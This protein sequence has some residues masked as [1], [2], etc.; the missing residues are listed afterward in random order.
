M[1]EIKVVEHLVDNKIVTSKGLFAKNDI[2]AG[3]FVAQMVDPLVIKLQIELDEI[4]AYLS[5]D[6]YIGQLD[7]FVYVSKTRIVWDRYFIAVNEEKKNLPTWY[8]MNHTTTDK[9]T[10]GVCNIKCHMVVK[11]KVCWS[12]R[13][14]VCKGEELLWDYLQPDINWQ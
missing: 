14:N 1:V 7:S 5:K 13:R 8:I 10:T 6:G 2:A 4:E 12:T 9:V 11:D 3:V